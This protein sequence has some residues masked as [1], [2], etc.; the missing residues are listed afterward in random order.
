MGK[1]GLVVCLQCTRNPKVDQN[2]RFIKMVKITLM[3]DDKGG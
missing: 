3:L 2:I 1:D